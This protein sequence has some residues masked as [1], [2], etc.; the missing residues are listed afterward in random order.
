MLHLMGLGLVM[1]LAFAAPPGIVTAETFRRG[2]SRGFVAA[3][4]V[5]LGSLIGDA[6]WAL[7]ALAGFAVIVQQPVAERVLAIAGTLFLLYTSVKGLYDNLTTAN[8]EPTEALTQFDSRSSFAVGAWLS[9][10]NPWAISYWIG[11]GGALAAS[12]ATSS[13]TNM[14]IFF[15]SFFSVCVVYAFVMSFAVKWTRQLL[16][17]RVA[18]AM[19]IA[20]NLMILWLGLSLAQQ[21]WGL[22]WHG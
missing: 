8:A 12:G 22:W 5:Q 3:L 10:S 15:L 14:T 19:S 13:F 9:L 11:P 2:L 17:P 1:G 20:C 18:R 21:V 6:T 16:S 7:L 4:G